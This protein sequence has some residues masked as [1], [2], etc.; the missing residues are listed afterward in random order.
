MKRTGAA[1]LLALTIALPAQADYQVRGTFMYKDR[2]FN[3]AGFS[4]S[5]P[6]RPIRFADV[7]VADA[8]TNVVLASGATDATGS[9]TLQVVDNLMRNLTVRVR[10]S[11]TRTSDLFV[12]VRHTSNNAI[13][14]VSTTYNSHGS[15][16]NIDFTAAPIVAVQG[17]GGDPFN[18]YDCAVDGMDFVAA[19][20]GA[21]PNASESLTLYWAPGSNLCTCYDIDTR[22]IYLFGQSSDSDAYDDTVILHEFGHYV[23]FVHGASDNPTGPHGPNDCLVSQLSWSE[24]YATFLQNLVRDWKG[25]SR[26]DLYVDTTGQPGTGGALLSYTVENPAYGRPGPGNEITVNATLWDTYDVTGTADGSPGTDDDTMRIAN[27]RGPFWDVLTNYFPQPAVTGISIEDYWNGWFA[28]GHGFE[29]EMRQ[30]FA[31]RGMEFYDDA[32]EP[33]DSQVQAR[34]GGIISTTTHHSTYPAGD[35]DWTRF[36]AVLGGIYVFET[37]NL[38]CGS[39]TE[40]RL[41]ASNGSTLLAQNDDRSPTDLSSRISWVATLSGPVYLQVRRSP[42][43]DTYGSFDLYINISVAVEVSDIQIG[44]T[45]A[46]V[47]LAWRAAADAAF[48]H[49]DVE[50]ADQLD[51]PWARRNDAPLAGGGGEAPLFEFVDAQVEAGQRYYYRLVGVESDGQRSFYG[52]WEIVAALPAR[53][54]LYPPQPNPFNPRT[55]LRFDLATSGPVTLRIHDLRGRAVRTLVGGETLPAGTRV[56][57]WDGRDDAGRNAASGIYW[58]RL[59]STQGRETQRAV[60]LR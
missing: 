59:D 26:P 12:T 51:G 33:D 48:S 22:S 20:N 34:N 47:R 52:P 41:W 4:G 46:G 5:E 16:Q 43:I 14:T 13:F 2:E 42:D 24:G 10:T 53:F 44:A 30:V 38:P 3:L 15:T 36:D 27:A 39:D 1:T 56:L 31:L 32:F 58:V 45:P 19:M 23:E 57:F 6:N 8:N 40:M 11:S 28:R 25:F 60:L 29:T 49:F 50:R 18:V 35:S 54:V 37:R 7:E 9:F 55:Q 21:R 17:A